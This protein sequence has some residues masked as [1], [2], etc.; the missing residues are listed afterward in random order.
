MTELG[1][2]RVSA[3]VDV[4]PA[5]DISDGRITR[6]D[7]SAKSDPLRAADAL[8]AQ[9]ARWLHVVDVDRAFGRPRRHDAT[10]AAIARAGASV[11]LGGGLDDVAAVREALAWGV[12]RVVLGVRASG[13]PG[14]LRTIVDAVGASNVVAGLD[15]RAGRL[16]ERRGSSSGRP[17]VDEA[18]HFAVEAGVHTVLYRDLDRDGTLAGADWSVAERLVPLGLAV[19][20]AGGVGSLDELRAARSAGVAA[21]VVGRGLLEGRFTYAEAVACCR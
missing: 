18:A 17:S 14:R 12:R 21:V 3:F 11:Q 9:G 16:A 10:I 7:G 8:V 5:I 19:I 6:A 4:I 13:G 20:V 2:R 15:A 1:T